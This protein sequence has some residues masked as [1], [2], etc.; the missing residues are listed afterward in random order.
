MTGPRD[1]GSAE[2]LVESVE[3]STPSTC[4]P[5]GYKRPHCCKGMATEH[6][7]AEL[8]RTPGVAGLDLGHQPRHAANKVAKDHSPPP[9]CRPTVSA[10][11]L[12]TAAIS[13]ADK[14]PES[15][16]PVKRSTVRPSHSEY[17]RHQGKRWL[18][19]HSPQAQPAARKLRHAFDAATRGTPDCTGQHRTSWYPSPETQRGPLGSR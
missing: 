6:I 13:S 8:R 2:P 11:T 4:Q 18:I 17:T 5:S 1:R 7:V 3:F 10:T 16:C 12:L 14:G 15:S 19:Q 9:G